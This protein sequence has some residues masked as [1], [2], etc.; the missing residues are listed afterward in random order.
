MFLA[1]LEVIVLVARETAS[2][3]IGAG[4]T[5]RI[6]DASSSEAGKPFGCQHRSKLL[7]RRAGKR[8]PARLQNSGAAVKAVRGGHPPARRQ[9]R[10][11]GPPPPPARRPQHPP[12]AP[13]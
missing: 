12:R 7:R 2:G 9:I 8:V 1:A 6:A 11:G 3:V 5:V 4:R 13:I 10:P